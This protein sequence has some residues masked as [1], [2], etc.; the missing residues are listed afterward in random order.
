MA[1][2][3][4]DRAVVQPWAARLVLNDG[5][6]VPPASVSAVISW[7]EEPNHAGEATA[8]AMG[9]LIGAMVTLAQEDALSKERIARQEMLQQ[10]GLKLGTLEGK[11]I[12]RC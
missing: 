1:H 10:R 4:L 9:G 6:A 2:G 8:V 5:R 7:L 11:S 12:I 3:G